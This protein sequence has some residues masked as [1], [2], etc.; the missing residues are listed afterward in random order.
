MHRN[1]TLAIWEDTIADD[2]CQ[3]FALSPADGIIARRLLVQSKHEIHAPV[4]A[5][6]VL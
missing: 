2:R 3:A 6:A 5:K 4:G 1:E